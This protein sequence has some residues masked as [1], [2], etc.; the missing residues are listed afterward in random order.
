MT[1]EE[2]DAWLVKETGMSFDDIKQLNLYEKRLLLGYSPAIV[3]Q[4][5]EDSWEPEQPKR[6]KGKWPGTQTKSE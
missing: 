5:D 1:P 2:A 6:A 3:V 4:L